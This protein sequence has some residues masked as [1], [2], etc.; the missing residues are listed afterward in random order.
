MRQYDFLQGL[1]REPRDALAVVDCLRS[2]LREVAGPLEEL[3]RDLS[4]ALHERL[5]SQSS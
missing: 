3:S 2:E 1:P 4:E 5:R